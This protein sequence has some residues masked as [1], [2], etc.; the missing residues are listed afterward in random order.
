MKLPTKPLVYLKTASLSSPNMKLLDRV[1]FRLHSAEKVT[2]IASENSGRQSLL[3]LLLFIDQIDEDGYGYFEMLGKDVGISDPDD[4]RESIAYLSDYPCMYSGTVRDNIDPKKEFSDEEIAKTLHFLKIFEA[5]QLYSGYRSSTDI[6]IQLKEREGK[7]RIQEY[8]V[9]ELVGL[10]LNNISNSRNTNPNQKKLGSLP[11]G[12]D[13]NR[14]K[15]IF[16]HEVSGNIENT[17]TI[18]DKS[19]SIKYQNSLYLE[20]LDQQRINNES[21]SYSSSENRDDEL[22]FGDINRFFD[23]QINDEIPVAERAKRIDPRLQEF[24]TDYKVF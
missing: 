23:E 21:I 7:I 10:R 12:L 4:L 18:L 14:R 15:A 1:T 2:F 9:E 5:L 13:Y 16:H 22:S 3:N 8:D 11:N 19:Q 17:N 24:N 20:Q 6:A